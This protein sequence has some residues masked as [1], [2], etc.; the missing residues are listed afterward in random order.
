MQHMEAIVLALFG[1]TVISALPEL[2]AIQT[3]VEAVYPETPVRIAFTSNQVRRIWHHRA[4]D[5]A[6]LAQHPDL[7][8]AVL[9]VQGILATIATLQD[10]GY[11]RLVVQSAH[12]APAEEFHDLHAYVRA[13][14]SIRT[15]KPRWQPF[16]ALTLGRP[17]LGAYNPKHPYSADIRLAAQALHAD[18]EL[19]RAQDAALVYMGHGNHFFPSGGL[20]LEFAAAMRDLAPDVVTLIGTV[21]GFPDFNEVIA[22]LHRH[23]V[24]RVLLK[25][26]LVVA[27]THAITDLVGPQEDSWSSILEQNG[28]TVQASVR[29]LGPQIAPIFVQH[30]ADAAAEAGMELR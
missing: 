15:L 25:P 12:I 17:L 13:L 4:S 5:P 21:E 14:G 8:E 22:Q 6:Y 30:I 29:G 18:L 26:F 16:Q 1:T 20:Y 24:Q 2:Q 23:R 19:A 11:D 27:G 9:S 28:F 3:A 10:R 7:P